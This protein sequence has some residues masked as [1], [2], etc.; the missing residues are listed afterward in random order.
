MQNGELQRMAL[1]FIQSELALA[2]QRYFL[3]EVLR[4]KSLYKIMVFSIELD[5]NNEFCFLRTQGRATKFYDVYRHSE[6][7]YVHTCIYT[8]IM[9]TYVHTYVGLHTCIDTHT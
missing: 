1:C 6:L 4:S 9:L 8:Y 7:T 2:Q 3:L 5:N